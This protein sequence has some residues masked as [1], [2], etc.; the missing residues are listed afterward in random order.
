MLMNFGTSDFTLSAWINRQNSGAIIT[1]RNT[2]S[3]GNFIAFSSQLGAE[4]D[5]SGPGDY[6]GSL[7]NPEVPMNTWTLATMV[8]E[9]NSVRLYNNG[10]LV[11]TIPSSS[12]QNINNSAIAMIGARTD[13]SVLTQFFEGMID[14][15]GIWNRVL[16]QQEIMGLFNNCIPSETHVYEHVC[17]TSMVSP[18]G[19]YT[20]T[21]AGRHNDTI[22]TPAGCDSVLVYH[23][24]FGS[25]LIDQAITVANPSILCEGNAE[26]RLANTQQGTFYYLRNDRTMRWLKVLSGAPSHTFAAHTS[27][28]T[29]YNVY[30]AKGAA[31]SLNGIDEYA[32]IIPGTGNNSQFAANRITMEAWVNLDFNN[33]SPMIIGE[34]Y[35]GDGT[36]LFS[37]YQSANNIIASFFDGS[38]H[39]VSSPITLNSWQHVAATYDKNQ[40]V[41][42]INGVQVAAVNETAP[43][44][45]SMEEWR[46]GRRWDHQE[47]IDGE[48]D[49]IRVWNV[50][51]TQAQIQ[52]AMNACIAGNEPG[53]LIFLQLR[54]QRCRNRPCR[55]RSHCYICKCKFNR[56]CSSPQQLRMH[57]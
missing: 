16:S 19:G 20:W 24:T 43:L 10:V 56:L 28:T 38:W 39:S 47:V 8:R 9:G 32:T 55:R 50:A 4:L 11:H 21:T 25:A 6:L 3:Y 1:K 5:E 45:A 36:V 22:V 29:T 26:I 48:L 46:V 52:A 27:D 15:L 34:S 35:L 13:G 37:I 30:A 42:Y 49:E 31:I 40:I 44:P 33:G 51:R 12:V 53:L 54:W 41:L 18:S 2:P 23:L 57:C 7:Q 17:G 14:D